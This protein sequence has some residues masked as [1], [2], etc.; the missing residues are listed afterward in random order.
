MRLVKLSN[1][2]VKSWGS[3]ML[4]HTIDDYEKRWLVSHHHQNRGQWDS[5]FAISPAGRISNEIRKCKN[6]NYGVLRIMNSWD[7]FTNPELRG[8]KFFDEY[9]L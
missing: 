3:C 6:I 8:Y 4:L 2:F 1:E 5:L 7:S 9:S